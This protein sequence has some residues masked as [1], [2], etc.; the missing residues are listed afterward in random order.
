MNSSKLFAQINVPSFDSSISICNLML[1]EGS[2]LQHCIAQ[3][4]WWRVELIDKVNARANIFFFPSYL[5]MRR[6]THCGWSIFSYFRIYKIFMNALSQ[7]PMKIRTNKLIRQQ[8]S[9]YEFTQN[10][11]FAFQIKSKR[12][13]NNGAGSKSALGKWVMAWAWYIFNLLQNIRVSAYTYT[14]I[15]YLFEKCLRWIEIEMCG[16]WPTNSQDARGEFDY[17]LLFLYEKYL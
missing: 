16:V 10:I 1:T 3:T 5:V 14:T 12:K 6:R 11:S 13:T 8:K 2:A 15:V 4:I 17:S 7:K 9:I